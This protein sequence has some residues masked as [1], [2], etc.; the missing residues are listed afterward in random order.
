[1]KET[2]YPKVPR[3]KSCIYK[4]SKEVYFCKQVGIP[5]ADVLRCVYK[6]EEE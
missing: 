3:C 6:K 4:K 5:C 2:K 1:M